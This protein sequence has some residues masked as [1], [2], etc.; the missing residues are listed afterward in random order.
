MGEVVRPHVYSDGAV[1]RP[2]H[3]NENETILYNVLTGN[4]DWANLK[5]SLANQAEGLVKLDEDA[6]VPAALLP[7]SVA[8][9]V[10]IVDAGDLYTA[11][12]VEAA[13]QEI[14]GAGRTTE[15]VV[16]NAAAIIINAAAIVVN[17]AA[18]AANAA[19]IATNAANIPSSNA[20]VKGWINFDGTGVIAIQDSFNV[21]SIVDEGVGQYTI[22]W[23]TN[24]AND[25]YAISIT[26]GRK[27]GV[28]SS[29]FG[30]IY[31]VATGSVRIYVI[32]HDNILVD[33]N[34]LCVI[35]IGDQ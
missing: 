27:D 19:D 25:D 20:V 12:E 23:N 2:D 13:L 9:N 1:A 34:A 24:F 6:K 18:A 14:A 35:A 3:A 11:T 33:T 16:A 4:I 5:A 29:A 22:N 30:T 31:T 32:K 26:A 15:T 17:A 21:S 28:A 10:D 7:D 8:A